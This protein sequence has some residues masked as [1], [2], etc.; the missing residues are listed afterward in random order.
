[1]HQHLFGRFVAWVCQSCNKAA[2]AIHGL[3]VVTHGVASIARLLREADDGLGYRRFKASGD[4][5]KDAHHV[6]LLVG[7]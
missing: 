6:S 4:G 5:W 3:T 1:M 7:R 2:E